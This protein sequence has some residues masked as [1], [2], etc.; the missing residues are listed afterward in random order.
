VISRFAEL[1]SEK[2]P[3]VTCQVSK[4]KFANSEINQLTRKRLENSAFTAGFK[5]LLINEKAFGV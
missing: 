2:R 3:A 1:S 5:K 4:V